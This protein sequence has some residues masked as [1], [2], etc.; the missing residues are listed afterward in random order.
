MKKATYDKS[1]IMTEAWNLF[2][3]DDIALADFEYL[4]FGELQGQKTFALCLKEAWAHE[5]EIVERINEKYADAENSEEAKAWDW[6]CKKLGLQIEMDAYTKMVNVND[7]RKEA[8]SGT[9]VWPLA[10]RAVKLHIKLF[11]QVA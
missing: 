10:M 6:A 1:G 9:S 11:G 3:N 8:W 5:K 4:T 7:M 2:N